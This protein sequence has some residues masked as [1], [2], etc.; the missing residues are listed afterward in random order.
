MCSPTCSEFFEDQEHTLVEVHYEKRSNSREK[1]TFFIPDQREVNFL[2]F[3]DPFDSILQALEKINVVSFVNISL[4]FSFCCEFPTCTS[5]CM[6][7]ES[8]SR[9][10]ENNHLLD[11]LHWKDHF[12]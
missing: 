5:F 11:W 7:E 6:L 8:E 9:I 12:T 10:Q 4:G 3:Q 2:D 1:S